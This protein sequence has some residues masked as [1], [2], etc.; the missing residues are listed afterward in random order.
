LLSLIELAHFGAEIDTLDKLKE[1]HIT[2]WLDKHREERTETWSLSNLD[3]LV[4]KSLNVKM[5][6]KDIPSRLTT[7]FADYT[8]LLRNNGISWVIKE[9]PKISV[10]HI[11]SA[12]RP[13][14]LQKRI[15]ED[16]KFR[17]SSL[18]KDWRAFLKHDTARTEHYDECG[19]Y[20][21]NTSA[22]ATQSGR[23]VPADSWKK[24]SSS[25]PTPPAQGK[26]KNSNA[27]SCSKKES[28]A[29]ELPDCLNNSCDGK[30]WLKDC[31]KSS[32]E[33][34]DVIFAARAQARKAA[35]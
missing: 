14:P 17:H 10:G 12:L 9:K 35:G 33:E 22:P 29:R 21:P 28:K 11:V 4:S 23:P 31:S 24:T 18:R 30:H 1:D 26:G 25:A 20:R 16:L 8:T 5:Q 19:D 2:A 3:F 7:L 15:R 13:T 32:Q 34:K 27:S 6:E